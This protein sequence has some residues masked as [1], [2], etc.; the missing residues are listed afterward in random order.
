MTQETED[1]VAGL[2]KR[3]A[4]QRENL[5][6]M[7]DCGTAW[8][9]L[10]RGADL[11]QSLSD[12]IVVQRE[13]LERIANWRRDSAAYTDSMNLPRRKMDEAQV[14]HIESEAAQALRASLRTTHRDDIER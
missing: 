8:P 7:L 1:V 13:A 9:E 5:G 2:R 10:E 3:A 4:W 6:D 14:I 11:I 12:R